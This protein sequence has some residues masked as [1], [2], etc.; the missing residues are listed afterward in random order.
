VHALALSELHDADPLPVKDC[1]RKNDFRAAYSP[2]QGTDKSQSG[3]H[4]G[5]LLAVRNHIHSTNIDINVLDNIADIFDTPLRFAA[6]VVHFKHVQVLMVSLYLWDSEGFS[7]RNNI[8]LVQIKM[9]K[10]LLSL[11]ILCV[12]DFNIKFEDFEA[13]EWPQKMGVDM[14]HPKMPTTLSSTSDRVIDYGFISK[15]IKVMY[16]DLFPIRGVPWGPHYAFVVALNSKPRSI[17]SRVQC[18]PKALP[19]DEFQAAWAKLDEDQRATEWAKASNKADRILK[20]QYCKT[21]YYILGSPTDQLASDPKFQGALLSDSLA[22][23][24]EAAHASLASEVLVLNIAGIPGNR[25]RPFTGRAQYPKFALKPTIP[26]DQIP[27]KTS[28]HLHYWGQVKGIARSLCKS[29]IDDQQDEFCKVFPLFANLLSFADHHFDDLPDTLR[30]EIFAIRRSVNCTSADIWSQMLLHITEVHSFFINKRLCEVRNSWHLF[31]KQQLAKG[32]G[33]LYQFIAKWDKQFLNVDWDSKGKHISPTGFFESEIKKWASLWAPADQIEQLVRLSAELRDFR[34]HALSS[35]CPCFGVTEFDAAIRKYRKDTMGCDLW[36]AT[37]L[38]ALP[39]CARS[40]I[41]NAI[42]SSI[43]K[44]AI[45]H[46]FLLSLN[47]LLGK[48][49]GDSRTV[50]KTPMLYRITTRADK[51]VRQWEVENAKSFDSAGV[52]SSALLAALGRNLTAEVAHWLGLFSASIFNDY[53]KF[54]DS[55]DIIKLMCESVYNQFPPR[56]L[57]FALMQHLAPRVLQS[58]GHSSIP[59]TIFK[60]ILAGCSFSVAMTRIYLY[61]SMTALVEKHRGADPKLFVDDTSMIASGPSCNDVLDILVPCMIDFGKKV[62]DLKLSLSPKAVLTSNSQRL[63]KLLSMELG[64]HHFKFIVSKAARDLGISHTSGCARPRKLTNSRI[65]GSRHRICKI[66]KLAKISRRARKLFTGSAFAMATWG[67]Q[68]SN[69]S[70]SQLLQ[71]ERDALSSSGIASAGRCRTVALLVVFGPLGTPRSRLVR[72]TIGAWFQLLSSLSPA[73]IDL[74]RK[75]WFE[76][77]TSLGDNPC[78]ND[79]KGIL[80]NV[81]YILIKARWKPIAYNAWRDEDQSLWVLTPGEVSPNAVTAAIVKATT[82]VELKNAALHYNGLGIQDGIDLDST[83]S[84]TR[85]LD[86]SK[87]AQFQT[88]CAVETVLS[89]GAWPAE[90]VHSIHPSFPST[91]NRC[92]HSNETALHTYW[93]CPANS[94]IEHDAVINTQYLCERAIQRSHELPCLWLRGLLPSH[95]TVVDP[96]HDPTDELNLIYIQPLDV[97]WVSG[98]YYGDASG[99]EHTQYP[100][101]RRVGVGLAKLNSDRSLCFGIRSNLPGLVQT[102][103]RGELFAL[104]ILLRLCTEDLVIDFVTDNKGVCDNFNSPSKGG[105]SMNCKLFKEVFQL[106]HNKNLKVSVRWMPSH[107]DNIDDSQVCISPSD[108]EGNKK[109]DEFAGLSAIELRLPPSATVGHIHYVK[110][111]RNIQMRLAVI[112]MH[113]PGRKKARVHRPA[114]SKP[115]LQEVIDESSHA[116]IKLPNRFQCS[117]CK[118]SFAAYD[119]ALK[120]WLLSCCPARSRRTGSLGMNTTGHQS[121]AEHTVATAGPSPIHS[122]GADSASSSSCAVPRSARR[123][124]FKG[125]HLNFVPLPGPLQHIDTQVSSLY[126]APVTFNIYPGPRPTVVPPEDRAIHIGNATVHASHVINT[127]RG[128]RYCARCGCVVTNQARKLSRQC[129]PPKAHGI[130]V[131]RDIYKDRL[132]RSLSLTSWPDGSPP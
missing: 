95:L 67:H 32:G 118:N 3:T 128:L 66:T 6:R 11:P 14:I 12:G 5:E 18:I 82:R 68:C 30:A 25:H 34:E 15:D 8:I 87:P 64:S 132:P 50:C 114:V 77:R 49:S 29:F 76:A 73:C 79:I 43:T 112:I 47:A 98:T 38:R 26:K 90:R 111:V 86:Q 120:T 115:R 65:C 109:A 106:I 93:E 27:F 123:M 121:A 60:S 70:V 97:I 4:G 113:L 92:G 58:N 40:A 102:V 81:I 119:G 101:L 89:A 35:S 108:L 54:F 17:F 9:L 94:N 20:K 48:P 69:V 85:S 100:K 53:H 19:M 52:G 10:D 24:Q 125:P 63:S 78:V 22:C 129:E 104:V 131:K 51:S 124:T 91:C 83:L 75:A 56:M 1:F 122:S 103:S 13:S 84:L 41:A 28:P 7:E 45:P 37:A 127:H 126:P 16:Q 99:G 80:S 116:I 62:K 42:A 33:Q 36:T 96:I 110:L 74:L 39:L 57:C 107:L 44:I 61:R 31:V 23:G 59:I 88:K 21:G 130:N 46:Q 105:L 117:L 71:L 55:I 2:A 72:E